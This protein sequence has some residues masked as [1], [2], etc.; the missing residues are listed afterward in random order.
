[1]TPAYGSPAAITDDSAHD[2]IAAQTGRVIHVTSLTVTNSHATVGTLVT[3]KSDSRVIWQGYCAPAG[4][5]ASPKFEPGI[6]GI[7]G[8]SISAI[9]GTTG[10]N[11]Y[12]SASGWAE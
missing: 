5:G 10:A 8:S 1:M 3:V 7:S 2:V 6:P 9:C 12:V 11:V 4:G